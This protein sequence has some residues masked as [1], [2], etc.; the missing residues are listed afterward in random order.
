MN[1]FKDQQVGINGALMGLTS[2]NI[3]YFKDLW[4]VIK[5]KYTIVTSSSNFS[6]QI[7][8][9]LRPGWKNL[10]GSRSN[11]LIV[12]VIVLIFRQVFYIGMFIFV[13]FLDVIFQNT[14]IIVVCIIFY[15]L[16]RLLK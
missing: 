4:N 5:P 7:H 6:T 14:I 9:G 10:L 15:N 11:L 13:L 1:R 12:A 8:F 3:K 16:Q 2:K